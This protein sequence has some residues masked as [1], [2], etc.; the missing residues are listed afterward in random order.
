MFSMDRQRAR[1]ESDPVNSA[2]EEDGT[3]D[4]MVNHPSS[5]TTIEDEGARDVESASVSEERLSSNGR[6]SSRSRSSTS[7]SDSNESMVEQAS[8]QA[9]NIVEQ[10]GDEESGQ[11][12]SE[13]ERI[14]VTAAHNR[15]GRNTM[16]LA[17][18]EEQ[19]E[20]SRRRSSA[21]VLLAVFVLFRL[22]IECLQ[23]QD[24][25]L[26]LLCL[27][28]TSWTARWIRYNREREEELDRRIEAYLQNNNNTNEVDRNEFARM[29]F[30]AQLAL[31]IM[32]SQRHMMEG[33]FGRPE[34][35]E[36]TPGVSDASKARWKQFQ[37][38]TVA[39]KKGDYGA[40]PPTKGDDLDHTCSICLSEYEDSE[41]LTQLPCHHI[42]H[43]EC[44]QSWTNNH[45]KCPLCNFDLETVPG[46]SANTPSAGESIV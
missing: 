35:Q 21:C 38:N 11:P 27:L 31:T 17:E 20:L 19:R 34:G 42:Y 23:N 12:S 40:L 13:G 22:W 18:L 6:N 45:V 39:S 24:P 43:G 9:D 8:L 37:W 7:G 25:T 46:E 1:Y 14:F 5:S 2:D 26:L 32:E 16:T 3:E 36:E 29:S 44:I 10:R 33:G 15:F 41:T 28:G 4:V 30:Q